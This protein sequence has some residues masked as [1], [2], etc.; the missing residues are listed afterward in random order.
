M[1]RG[2]AKACLSV[3][4]ETVTRTSRNVVARIKGTDKAEEILTLTAHYDSVPEGPGAYDNMSAA[5][6]SKNTDH[7]EQWNSYGLV[8]KRKVCLEVGTILKH[9]KQNFRLIVS[10]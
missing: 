2:A 1:T 3:E 4:Q 8:Q 9:M 5:D 10:I 6:I 7:A